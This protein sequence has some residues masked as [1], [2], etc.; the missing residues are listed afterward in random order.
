V[1]SR[2]ETGV[3]LSQLR[4][5]AQR[6]EHLLDREYGHP[7]KKH[8]LPP[9]A[10]LILTV[11]SQHTSDV[12][13]DRAFASL[14]SRFQT[15]AEVADATTAEVAEAIRSA[16]LAEIKAPRIQEILREIQSREGDYSLGRLEEMET[17]EARE[18]LLSLKGVG[19]KTAA[20]VLMFSLGRP[21]MPV[22]THVHRVS[23]RL[24]LIPPGTTADKAHDLLQALYRDDEVYA[25][26]INL[27]RHGRQTCH[28]RNPA[29]GRCPLLDECDYGQASVSNYSDQAG[30]A[31]KA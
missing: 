30:S 6:I 22:D 5:K 15:W 17:K 26:H 7:P 8:G 24:G 16:G 2:D 21:V 11:L 29:C 1:G 28:A 19:P 3:S 20:C 14:V 4:G 10:S 12:N 27:I 25:A 13:S 23:L 9:L 18:Y 31:F